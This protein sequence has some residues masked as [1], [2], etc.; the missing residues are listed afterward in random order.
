MLVGQDFDRRLALSPGVEAEA[1]RQRLSICELGDFA[2]RRLE[3]R[4]HTRP[5]YMNEVCVE[6]VVFDARSEE[7][8]EEI[9]LGGDAAVAGMP[10]LGEWFF[11]DIPADTGLGEAGRAGGEFD[12]FQVA[13]TRSLATQDFYEFARGA[14]PD[15]FP[16]AT[17]ERPVG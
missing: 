10:S 17:L 7:G 15:R 12:D 11:V 5:S 4:V 9:A 2:Q 8:R 6:E 1:G 16:E 3:A 14:H 13:S